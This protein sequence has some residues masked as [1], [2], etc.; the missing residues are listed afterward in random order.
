MKTYYAKMCVIFIVIIFSQR[1]PKLNL[2]LRGGLE[3]AACPISWQ[4]A[5]LRYVVRNICIQK[6]LE[7]FWPALFVDTA[8]GLDMKVDNGY[9]FSS[10]IQIYLLH[11]GFWWPCVYTPKDFV[12]LMCIQC[13]YVY[14]VHGAA[15]I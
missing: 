13:I 15:L 9:P 10:C 2:R 4:S 5:Y 7:K 1:I 14:I 3:C 8:A 6:H 12:P 11:G